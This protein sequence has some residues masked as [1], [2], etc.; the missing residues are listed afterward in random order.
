VL[1]GKTPRKRGFAFK[2]KT[3]PSKV[4]G[5]VFCL[6]L[7]MLKYYLTRNTQ[8]RYFGKNIFKFTLMF[9]AIVSASLLIITI[10]AELSSSK[11]SQNLETAQVIS[12]IP[13]K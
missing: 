6:L 9:L 11:S 3:T 8:M 5:V 12:S 13:K 1:V 4:L 2:Q 10:A 7:K